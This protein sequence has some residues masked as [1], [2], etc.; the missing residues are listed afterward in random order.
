[1]TGIQIHRNENNMTNLE[2]HAALRHIGRSLRDA[3]IVGGSGGA[4]FGIGHPIGGAYLGSM[5][6]LES[7]MRTALMA[8][9][10]FGGGQFGASLGGAGGANRAFPKGRGGILPMLLAALG[11]A[12]GTYGGHKAHQALRPSYRKN[13]YGDTKRRTPAKK[14]G[15]PYLQ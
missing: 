12:G 13:A 15:N 2:K 10:G 8:G 6:D 5:P 3:G 9:G 11:A 7:V 14:V 1:M 4:L